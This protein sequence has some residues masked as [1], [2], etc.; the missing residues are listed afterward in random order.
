MTRDFLH[1]AIACSLILPFPAVAQGGDDQPDSAGREI[2]SGTILLQQGDYREAKAHFERAQT[3]QG[4]PT[5][6]TSAGISL[7]ELQM[8]H[9]EASRQIANL[10]LQLVSNPTH[11]PRPI[12]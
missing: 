9:F 4:K 6:E 5:E 1:C 10:E 11:V 3:L 8:G 12:T 7:A 2:K